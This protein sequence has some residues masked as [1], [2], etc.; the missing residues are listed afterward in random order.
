MGKSAMASEA[1]GARTIYE[2]HLQ[3]TAQFCCLCSDNAQK[4]TVKELANRSIAT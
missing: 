1:A 2:D 4:D 3:K